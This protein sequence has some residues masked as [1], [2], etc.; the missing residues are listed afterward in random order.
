MQVSQTERKRL[1]LISGPSGFDPSVVLFS[2]GIELRE[3]DVLA[4]VETEGNVEVKI[5]YRDDL[6]A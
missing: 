6:A 2:Q 1:V 3:D 4:S 5:F